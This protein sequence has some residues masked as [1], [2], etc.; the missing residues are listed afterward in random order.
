MLGESRGESRGESQGQPRGESQGQPR[1][2]RFDEDRWS[3]RLRLLMV[4]LSSLILWS[5]IFL[6]ASWIY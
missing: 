5:G 1:G 3:P 6:V 4:V 2:D